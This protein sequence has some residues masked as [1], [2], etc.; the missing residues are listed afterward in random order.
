MKAKWKRF[1]IELHFSSYDG[2][3]EALYDALMDIP[4][5]DDYRELN[6]LMALCDAVIWHPF[7][8]MDAEAL[9]S[10]VEAAAT[11]AQRYEGVDV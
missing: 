2:A 3:P 7:E 8:G 10:S 11:D 6:K 9:R 4:E 1:A 5:A